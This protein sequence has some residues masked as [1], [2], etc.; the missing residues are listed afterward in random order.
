MAERIKLFLIEGQRLSVKSRLFFRF[1][2][3]SFQLVYEKNPDAKLM[4][5]LIR[6]A[7]KIRLLQKGFGN[8]TPAVLSV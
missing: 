4:K 1:Q 8:S 2:R 3:Y 5:I 7:L 6:N